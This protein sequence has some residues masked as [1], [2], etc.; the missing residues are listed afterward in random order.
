MKKAE[1]SSSH[2]TVFPPSVHFHMF[3]LY[4]GGGGKSAT[5][6]KVAVEKH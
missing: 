6:A 1:A 5:S 2:K 4:S 3:R